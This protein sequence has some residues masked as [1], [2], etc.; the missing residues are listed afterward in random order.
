MVN[1]YSTPFLNVFS[2]RNQAKLVMI[3]L[4]FVV[5]K[6]RCNNYSANGMFSVSANS[7]YAG[8]QLVEDCK[9]TVLICLLSKYPFQEV[10]DSFTPNN[11]I[12]FQNY[13]CFAGFTNPERWR[14]DRLNLNKSSSF[15]WQM[16]VLFP[17]MQSISNKLLECEAN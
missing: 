1:T 14:N 6:R 12:T 13:V 15:W 11:S 16:F 10:W 3:L 4:S 17:N 8:A 9:T 2:K 7:L 5:M